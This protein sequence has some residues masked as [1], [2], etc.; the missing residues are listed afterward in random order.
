MLQEQQV[1]VSMVATAINEMTS[2]TVEIA[3]NAED[4]ANAASES[5]KTAD[6]GM[7]IISG[8]IQSISNLSS[9]IKETSNVVEELNTHVQEINSILIAIQTIADQTNLL[10]LNAAIEAARAGDAGRGFAVVADEVRTLSQKTHVS[11]GEIQKTI[12]TLQDIV[13]KATVLMKSSEELAQSTVTES[14]LVA[15]SFSEINTSIQHISDMSAQIATAVEQQTA[16]TEEISQNVN[17]INDV[18]TIFSSNAEE[19]DK[20]AHQ[21]NDEANS[22]YDSVKMYKV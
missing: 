10:A 21:L 19:S 18:S 11:T 16:V 12:E 8:S 6:K 5:S 15:N 3:R 20:Q 13:G 7:D 1:E 17:K 9:E 4:A 22:L 2:A 14:D